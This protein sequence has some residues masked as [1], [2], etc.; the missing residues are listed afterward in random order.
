MRH[1]HKHEFCFSEKHAGSTYSSH[2][3]VAGYSFCICQAWMNSLSV[4][5]YFPLRGPDM[6]LLFVASSLMEV[7]QSGAE[8]KGSQSA[9][10]GLQLIGWPHSCNMFYFVF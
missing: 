8:V 2:V 7:L 1:C 5:S 10:R 4:L 9:R 6:V 3:R